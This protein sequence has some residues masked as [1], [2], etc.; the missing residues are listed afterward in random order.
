MIHRREFAIAYHSGFP[1]Y[2][3]RFHSPAGLACAKEIFTPCVFTQYFQQ[4]DYSLRRAIG[5][6]SMSG[7]GPSRRRAFARNRPTRHLRP[8][9]LLPSRRGLRFVRLACPATKVATLRGYLCG[10]AVR[11]GRRDSRA[12]RDWSRRRRGRRRN[13]AAVVGCRL[14]RCVARPPSVAGAAV[15]RRV[16]H[17]ARGALAG[18]WSC[19]RLQ[20]SPSRPLWPGSRGL[21]SLVSGSAPWRTSHRRG[22]QHTRSEVAHPVQIRTPIR[23]GKRAVLALHGAEFPTKTHCWKLV[24]LSLFPAAASFF[25]FGVVLRL[26]VDQRTADGPNRDRCRETTQIGR[27]GPQN[28]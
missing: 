23:V 6:T 26:G 2:Q 5:K 4:P 11:D 20:R 18:M 1:S 14:R 17:A 19:R 9:S 12:S 7:C 22:R 25:V 27:T 13:A 21:P 24:A 28:R 10:G 16:Q 3:T 8:S 15:V